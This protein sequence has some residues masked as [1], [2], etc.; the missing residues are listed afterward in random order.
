MIYNYLQMLFCKASHQ[1][2]WCKQSPG[3]IKFPRI[4]MHFKLTT[5]AN[6]QAASTP[7]QLLLACTQIVQ[8]HTCTAAIFYL[9]VYAVTC[10]QD[11]LVIDQET[12]APPPGNAQC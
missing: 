8:V 6:H 12:A 9:Q 1:M 5:G 3:Q 10:S 2:F 7:K 11:Q 4:A